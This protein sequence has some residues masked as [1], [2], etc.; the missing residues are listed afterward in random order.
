MADKVTGPDN[1]TALAGLTDEQKQSVFEAI[2][3]SAASNPFVKK[4]TDEMT[5][6][7]LRIKVSD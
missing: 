3:L 7:S 1:N 4:L 5:E 2:A 6:G